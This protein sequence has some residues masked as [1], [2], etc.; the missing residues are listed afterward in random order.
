MNKYLREQ[1]KV[2]F[3]G[4]RPVA[5][6]VEGSVI[7]ATQI[8]QEKYETRNQ[9]V[10]DYLASSYYDPKT[11]GESLVRDH[12]LNMPHLNA[13]PMM[14]TK[15]LIKMG[16]GDDMP[17]ERAEELVRGAY[18]VYNPENEKAFKEW[19]DKSE[20]QITQE[21]TE[22]VE[23][24]KREENR[25]ARTRAMMSYGATVGYFTP[26][27]I[28]INATPEEIEA[29]KQKHA[30]EV[31]GQAHRL[32]IQQA[33]TVLTPRELSLATM[34]GTAGKQAGK[35]AEDYIEEIHA[36]SPEDYSYFV[37]VITTTNPEL[38]RTFHERMRGVAGPL[39]QRAADFGQ[40]A[41]DQG[42]DTATYFDTQAEFA[43]RLE[44]EFTEEE[45]GRLWH[46]SDVP[47][48]E[49]VE[50]Y[51]KVLNEA[52][53]ITFVGGVMELSM[54]TGFER[55]AM[56]KEIESRRNMLLMYGQRVYQAELAKRKEDQALAKITSYATP[57]YS[58]LGAF[59]EGVIKVSEIGTDMLGL[60]TIAA[61][62]TMAGGPA[63]GA[64]L[65]FGFSY[66]SHQNEMEREMMAKGMDAYEAR[67]LSSTFSAAW[68]AIEY[69]QVGKLAKS[70]NLWKGFYTGVKSNPKQFLF[71]A[72]QFAKRQAAVGAHET[73][74]EYSQ[75]MIDFA[76]RE[77][78]RLYFD[79]NGYT[80]DEN[81][82]IMVNEIVEATKYM[83][84]VTLFGGGT[85]NATQN[86]V[87]GKP[88][89]PIEVRRWLRD[90]GI[91]EKKFEKVSA[92]R[93]RLQQLGTDGGFNQKDLNALPNKVLQVVDLNS[94]EEAAEI[95]EGLGY[96]PAEIPDVIALAET[97]LDLM[98]STREIMQA[99]I[100]E[101]N[102]Q[103]ELELAEGE[104]TVIDEIPE[105]SIV[106]Q[107]HADF[108]EALGL[109]L[110][111]F[112]TE[113]DALEAFPQL[114]RDDEAPIE[115]AYLPVGNTVV[116]VREN[117]TSPQHAME[118]WAHEV[119]GHKGLGLMEQGRRQ[120]IIDEVADL[121]G[122][123][124]IRGHL[125]AEYAHLN[126]EGLVGEYMARVIGRAYATGKLDSTPQDKKVWDRFKDWVARTLGIQ[127]VYKMRDEQIMSLAREVF[128]YVRKQTAEGIAVQQETAVGTEAD[129]DYDPDAEAEYLQAMQEQ[130]LVIENTRQRL[131]EAEERIRQKEEEAQQWEQDKKEA[132]ERMRKQ[133]EKLREL[134]NRDEI[135]KK[136]EA[137]WD[138][139]RRRRAQRKRN[140]EVAKLEEQIEADRQKAEEDI[141]TVMEQELERLQ[142][143]RDKIEA[144]RTKQEADQKAFDQER[145]ERNRQRAENEALLRSETFNPNTMRNRLRLL[146]WLRDEFTY[147]Q[148][149]AED[150][151]AKMRDIDKRR[152]LE[153]LYPESLMEVQFSV[154]PAKGE[155]VTD[156]DAPPA[157]FDETVSFSVSPA[158]IEM[159]N[160][161]TQ[162]EADVLDGLFQM[163]EIEKGYR[164]LRKQEQESE[165][166]YIMGEWAEA[167]PKKQAKL[168]RLKAKVPVGK[169]K[170][171]FNAREKK[172]A[173]AY[174]KAFKIAKNE[175]QEYRKGT[176]WGNIRSIHRLNAFLEENPLF[177]K[178]LK[179]LQ[180][181]LGGKLDFIGE[182]GKFKPI[183][184][185]T[186]VRSDRDAPR[187]TRFQ[188]SMPQLYLDRIDPKVYAS[189]ASKIN[190]AMEQVY[191]QGGELGDAP[192]SGS[193]SMKQIVSEKNKLFVQT[194]IRTAEKTLMALNLN[195]ACPMFVI[196]NRGC[197]GDACYLTQM[198]NAPTGTT[199]FE[200]AMYAG[201]ILQMT[202]EDI[203]EINGVGGLRVNGVGDTTADN[204]SQMRSAIKHAAM[205]GLKMKM[206]SK[207]E[208]SLA[209]LQQLH[210]EG[211]DVSHVILQPSV[212]YY[213]RPVEMDLM[214]NNSGAREIA[215]TDKAYI[216]ELLD[217]DPDDPRIEAIYGI[218]GRAVKK[219]GDTWYRKDGYTWEQYY[220]LREKYPDV[221]L[222]PRVVVGSADEIIDSAVNHKG[223]IITLMHG[224]LGEGII[225]DM[226]DQQYNY[227]TARHRF[228]L[229]DGKIRVFGDGM[230]GNKEI[231][232]AGHKVLEDQINN[233]YSPEQI[234][235]I[236]QNLEDQTCCQENDSK[237]ACADCGSHCAM[238][239]M[240][241]D[242]DRVA[243]SGV[244]SLEKEGANEDPDARLAEAGKA[245][246]YS[247]QQRKTPNRE[248]AVILSRRIV[249]GKSVTDSM[250]EG[251][252]V[253]AGGKKEDVQDVLENA[254]AIAGDI[255]SR[256]AEFDNDA[257]MNA[258]IRETEIR[259][260]YMRQNAKIYKD[261]ERD[262]R[263]EQQAQEKVKRRMERTALAESESTSALPADDQ[264][265]LEIKD[266]IAQM[267]VEERA[268]RPDKDQQDTA[269]DEDEEQ[270]GAEEGE[271]TDLTPEYDSE[272]IPEYLKRVRDKVIESLPDADSMTDPEAIVRYRKTMILLLNKV[273]GELTYGRT[274]VSLEKRMVQMRSLRDA[275]R[276]TVAAMNIIEDAYHQRVRDDV[277][278]LREAWFKITRLP[279]G[280]G[281]TT[282]RWDKKK[283]E[284]KYATAVRLARQASE[285]SLEDVN[286][287]LEKIEEEI[288]ELRKYESTPKD[289]Q[290]DVESRMEELLAE[291]M[292][293]EKFGALFKRDEDGLYV[294]SLAEMKDAV[295]WAETSMRE[296]IEKQASRI[297]ERRKR[298][299]S[300]RE[301]LIKAV[302]KGKRGT[303][304][305][306]VKDTSKGTSPMMFEDRLYDLIRFA[307]GNVYDDAEA[308]VKDIMLEISDANQNFR[309][310]TTA[311][312]DELKDAVGRIFGLKSRRQIEAKMYE[313]GKPDPKYNKFSK[314]NNVLSTQQ[315]LQLIAW[316]EQEQY[317]YE[318]F[319]MGYRPEEMLKAVSDQEY[320]LLE[321]MRQYYR[322]TRAEL[323]AVS[324]R[325]TGLPVKSPDPNYM[326]VK[327]WVGK[328]LEH[329]IVPEIVPK[330]LSTRKVSGRE[331]DEMVGIFDL[332]SDRV[333]SNAVFK[334][335]SSVALDLRGIFLAED[336]QREI[337]N[338]FGEKYFKGLKD[339]ATDIMTQKP[340]GGSS[341][342][343]VK[344]LMGFG[345]SKLWLSMGPAIA[346][347]SSAPA[348][349]YN[350]NA[351]VVIRKMAMNPL[352]EERRQA[353][354]A[355]WTSE[356]AKAR[357][358][359]GNSYAIAEAFATAKA[360]QN[361]YLRA[362]R[363]AGQLGLRPNQMMDLITITLVGS[364]VYQK[365]MDVA[366]DMFD[367]TQERQDWAMRKTWQ[368]VEQS[369]QSSFISQQAAWQRASGAGKLL[370]IFTSTVQ[371]YLSREMREIRAYKAVPNKANAVQL[372]K[373]LFI[374]HVIMPSLYLSLK[375]LWKNILGQEPDEDEWKQWV[376][377]ALVGPFSSWFVAGSIIEPFVNSMITGESQNWMG[378]SFVPASSI[379]KDF[380]HLGA[381]I[382]EGVHLEWGEAVDEF[383]KIAA[384]NAPAYRDLR[385]FMKNR[386]GKDI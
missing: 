296:Q 49:F 149:K 42:L 345:V 126:K 277:K 216:Q 255:I 211:V 263:I 207:Q 201:E 248:I 78:A 353:V 328:G 193:K 43:M 267:E 384:S 98:N 354:A 116:L 194:P 165:V 319:K 269:L 311:Q 284:E 206:I 89:A 218:Y 260:H 173:E 18:E 346:Q 79:V 179:E 341:N 56:K 337:R 174:R 55:T 11:E 75:A 251:L 40:W 69:M 204:V 379:I 12:F 135:R 83:P 185:E 187:Y 20:E 366:M 176:E 93:K 304:G 106:E 297:E 53:G 367:T 54:R 352:N 336:L 102:Q 70:A 34:L 138:A 323:S 316:V 142:G 15:Q 29:Q 355:M 343:V 231:Q 307:R 360:G 123:G 373:V 63:G 335:Y 321:W 191:E 58:D 310:E 214:E 308:V 215:G 292:A 164:K 19:L 74:E 190:E 237:D 333:H 286:L 183:G 92:H 23:A 291:R 125:G 288:N 318:A 169:K 188:R 48:R 196:G 312:M 305:K 247:V 77:T 320:E 8:E 76:M 265:E 122:I 103:K 276:I 295:D 105:L 334:H 254:R 143:Q 80:W 91:A 210:N 175:A 104:D 349:L 242:F 16:L 282:E 376:T 347:L 332:F 223:S 184:V 14:T 257:R 108:G 241:D 264:E 136:V 358:G 99:E 6:Y 155:A 134:K 275:D 222:Q 385:K 45:L 386:Y 236:Y 44:R 3:T 224:I 268:Y 199:L 246:Q 235:V 344:W 88:L 203:D 168:E 342:T 229:V 124:I 144:E 234:K 219:V 339:H 170:K 148:A 233:N 131:A 90:R 383:K 300:R 163:Y 177:Q 313:L 5:P 189:I 128:D 331:H 26:K 172:A 111:I 147:D 351:G 112:E 244:L 84:F 258:A 101:M 272:V 31:W 221:Q 180:Y 329:I 38:D 61:V 299:T 280:Q 261:G 259:Q 283:L 374:N 7:R 151:Y 121:V 356:Q 279:K 161:W 157:A 182:D 271:E 330:S 274:R 256:K 33:Q 200:R 227:G 36:M 266:L 303:K 52:S 37:D 62:G 95:L 298:H 361:P 60:A 25:K 378:D 239:Q 270:D 315:M 365:H 140:E 232:K 359:Q 287:R 152:I 100:D 65:A 159:V 306:P 202:Q 181:K 82:E 281:N 262:G 301:A 24:Q 139:D 145:K 150:V 238:R 27:D 50:R 205:R 47:N 197:W 86:I 107:A 156:I 324:E 28:P 314:Q 285:K 66:G 380:R 357:L 213:W 13:D 209:M 192:I 10:Y 166:Q 249:D 381:M 350:R 118:I 130:E 67:I 109:D 167:F 293:L 186:A 158:K 9:K 72:G 17:L 278:T 129:P 146:Q 46:S 243:N 154:A 371:Q 302:S 81:A 97:K 51:N 110:Q 290:T 73:V 171:D 87:T 117:L 30:E 225:S 22:A 250:A 32:R 120:E 220:A 212:D 119:F 1:P 71:Y 35:L 294:K 57:H 160:N 4:Q 368:E 289:K 322:D 370:G 375:N 309:M 252:L 377:Y 195:S 369:Q 153:K 2:N 21:A 340:L 41:K 132:S 228:E 326:P 85:I 178:Q 59:R 141:G 208:L 137:Q 253:R 363:R 198:A 372:G 362:V 39:Q 114:R 115:G 382:H 96:T 127:D 317:T 113:A 338:N 240:I 348:F 364:A 162:D 68:A 273:I 64:G 245:P 94:T 230:R 327:L 226:N 133:I 217:S 325:I